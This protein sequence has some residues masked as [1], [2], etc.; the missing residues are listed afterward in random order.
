MKKNEEKSA[1]G[2][3]SMIITIVEKVLRNV[4]RDQQ[5]MCTM[6]CTVATYNVGL[7]T[8]TLYLPP[9]F[10]N[11]STVNYTNRTGATLLPG[12]KVY[13]LYKYGDISQGWIAH[14]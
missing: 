9:D 4:L 7:G 13:L 14:K 1:V 6:A 8:A 11:A 10:T 2:L 12:Q 5:V 3:Y